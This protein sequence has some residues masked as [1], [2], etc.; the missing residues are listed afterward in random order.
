MTSEGGYEGVEGTRPYAGTAEYYARYRPRVSDAFLN[1]LREVLMWTPSSRVLDLGTG[2]GHLAL[3]VAPLVGEVVGVDPESDMLDAA[4]RIAAEERIANV[5]FVLGSS[6]DLT[7][8]GVGTFQSVTMSA[9]FH[10]MLDKDR[11]MAD[12]AAMTSTGD[13]SVAFVTTGVI[14]RPSAEFTAA[15]E[16][17]QRLLDQYLAGT[18]SGPHPRGRHDPFEDIL[19]R[20]AFRQIR[21]IETVY[22]AQTDLTSDALLGFHYSISHVLT[23]LGPRRARLEVEAAEAIAELGTP[24][25]TTVRYRDSALIGLRT[26]SAENRQR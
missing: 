22:E 21:S 23:R 17:V 8:L 1:Q 24:P 13:G 9:S 20:S 2:P 18:P 14:D 19:S 12:L 5:R 4:N 7:S 15:A 26:T 16:V 11:V 25:T 6:E 3:R 10:W